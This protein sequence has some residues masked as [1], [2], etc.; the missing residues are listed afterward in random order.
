LPLRYAFFGAG[1][2]VAEINLKPGAFR[3]LA[4][5]S[6]NPSGSWEEGTF[7]QFSAQFDDD[8]KKAAHVVLR[9]ANLEQKKLLARLPS[10]AAA[11]T[12]G[13]VKLGPIDWPASEMISPDAAQSSFQDTLVEDKYSRL[14]ER[15]LHRGSGAAF[16]LVFDKAKSNWFYIQE[17]EVSVGQWKTFLDSEIGKGL[18]L[19]LAGHR[20][21]LAEIG[22]S[23]KFP[24]DP[25]EQYLLLAAARMKA[26]DKNAGQAN[27]D[28]A[29]TPSG[30]GN[31]KPMT[32][33]TADDAAA[34]C[35]WLTGELAVASFKL[36]TPEQWVEAAKP[37]ELRAAVGGGSSL[38]DLVWL[39]RKEPH[40]T[41]DSSPGVWTGSRGLSSIF[42]NVGELTVDRNNQVLEVGGNF[43]QLPADV[44]ALVRS[45]RRVNE[46]VASIFTG[47]RPV[48]ISTG[49]EG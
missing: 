25:L 7:G 10:V 37:N 48:L 15:L 16:R 36:P 21:Q 34:Y 45:G 14:R 18:L 46:G 33:V 1:Q 23:G 30:W 20:S 8:S 9:S 12:E 47:F 43:R 40:D 26:A 28:T 38:R 4:S 32:Y 39:G 3:R 44:E 17:T 35:S 31:A 6:L 27:A 13:A 24:D 22:F 11:K 49:S 2:N 41:G 5:I 29:L 19:N 42:G